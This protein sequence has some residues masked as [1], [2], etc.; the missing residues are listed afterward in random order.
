MDKLLFADEDDAPPDDDAQAVL[1]DQAAAVKS[2]LPS[3]R[4]PWAKGTNDDEPKKPR[5]SF[6]EGYSLHADLAIHQK[7]RRK[8][9]RLLRYGLR[10]S[11]CTEEALA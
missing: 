8:L 6:F 11:L 4:F 5:C 9:E 3:S 2:P 10:A 1:D 7:E